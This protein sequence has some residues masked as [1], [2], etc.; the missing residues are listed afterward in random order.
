MPSETKIT[1]SVIIPVYNRAAIISRAIESVLRQTI[2][3]AELIV[4]DDGSED[5]TASVLKPYLP[6]IKIIRQENKGVSAARN[7]GIRAASGEWIALLDSDDEWLPQKLE[8]AGR[9]IQAH[10][11]CKIFQA[12]EIWMRNGRRVNPK[13]RHK[14]QGGFIYKESLPL[15]I[16]SPSAVVIKRSLFTEIGFFDETLPVCEDYDLWLRVSRKYKIGLDVHPGIVKY[17]GHGDQLSRKFWGMDRFRILAMEKQL[18]DPE[19]PD[20]LR[21]WTLEEILSK[22]S[23]LIE[24]YE[25]HGRDSRNLQKKRTQYARELSKL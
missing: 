12:E 23:V 22:L 6:Q 20:E 8:L 17:G 1:F 24:G 10:P 18:A 9:Y 4:V 5:E 19:L 21:K 2:P 14:K 7:A 16:V 15:C 13:N 3:P 25:K 11:D